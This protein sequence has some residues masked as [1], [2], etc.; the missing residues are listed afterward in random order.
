M[1]LINASENFEKV[2]SEVT[3]LRVSGKELVIGKDYDVI[4]VTY[5]SGTVEEFSYKLDSVEILKLRITYIDSTKED[6]SK[7]E[8]V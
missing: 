7:V 8:Q 5:P 1:D 3:R 4:D 2:S 6:I